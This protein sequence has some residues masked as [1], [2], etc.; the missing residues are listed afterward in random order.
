MSDETALWLHNF[1]QLMF[2]VE[3]AK[4][5]FQIAPNSKGVAEKSTKEGLRRG[6]FHHL[7]EERGRKAIYSAQLSGI[8]DPFSPLSSH[9][10]MSSSRLPNSW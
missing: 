8:V 1:K 4:D 10:S 5:N 7:L 2:F 3:V 9:S 6:V